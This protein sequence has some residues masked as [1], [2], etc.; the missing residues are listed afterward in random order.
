MNWGVWKVS[1]LFLKSNCDS[2]LLKPLQKLAQLDEEKHQTLFDMCCVWLYLQPKLQANFPQEVLDKY[3][4]MFMKGM[5]D[6]HESYG[7][8]YQSWGFCDWLG[9]WIWLEPNFW[10]F[11]DWVSRNPVKKSLKIWLGPNRF[12][13]VVAKLKFWWGSQKPRH[14][15]VGFG[16]FN[17]VRTHWPKIKCWLIFFLNWNCDGVSRNPVTFQSLDWLG[18]VDWLFEY[19]WTFV[20][21]HAQKNDVNLSW[22]C[23]KYE[24]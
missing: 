3:N 6:Y 24:N 23:S 13:E 7:F 2:W 9:M 1:C 4:Q 20:F 8:R 17:Y 15:L 5:L 18:V 14:N 16:G 12:G 10:G 11:F 21:F 19:F 22:V